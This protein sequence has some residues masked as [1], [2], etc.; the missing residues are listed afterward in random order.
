[1]AAGTVSWGR[2]GVMTQ[3]CDLVIRAGRVVTG[4]AEYLADVGILGESIAQIGGPMSG[5]Y[6]VDATGKLVIP[7]GIDAHV[8][9]TPSEEM[10]TGPRWCDDLYAGTRGA[11][12]GGITTVGNMTF[13]YAGESLR[14]AIERDTLA[15]ERDAVVD[16][17]LH[18]VLTDPVAQ[19]LTDLPGL[20]QRR[21]YLAQILHELWRLHH[22][23]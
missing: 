11:A 20:A 15:A 4:D 8:H 22:P 9:L 6:E 17:F 14:T 2:K 1:M 21:P 12:A 23:A 5:R 7:G 10:L 19:P 3:Q 13:P 16:V 18:P